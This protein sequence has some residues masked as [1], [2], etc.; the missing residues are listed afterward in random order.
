MNIYSISK[1]RANS[2]SNNKGVQT[3]LSELGR[4]TMIYGRENFL[5]S[6]DHPASRKASISWNRIYRAAMTPKQTVDK[7][8]FDFSLRGFISVAESYVFRWA[9]VCFEVIR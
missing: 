5:S 6:A 8:L 1:N 3:S 2:N 9:S 4:I 7:V